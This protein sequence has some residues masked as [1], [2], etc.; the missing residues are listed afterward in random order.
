MARQHPVSLDDLESV[1][2]RMERTLR[3]GGDPGKEAARGLYLASRYL[4]LA[5]GPGDVSC[6]D[7][8]IDSCADICD[9]IRDV[10]IAAGGTGGTY[11]ALLRM[12]KTTRLALD[13]LVVRMI[14]L[15][16][17]MGAGPGR[18]SPP[19]D[20]RMDAGDAGTL[21]RA[22]AGL[23]RYAEAGRFLE[24]AGDDTGLAIMYDDMGMHHKAA[25]LFDCAGDDAEDGAERALYAGIAL[26][27]AGAYKEA[28]ESLGRAGGGRTAAYY[29]AYSWYRLGEYGMAAD[30]YGRAGGLGGTADAPRMR[31]MMLGMDGN[32]G[33]RIRLPLLAAS[34][35][36]GFRGMPELQYAVYLVQRREGTS[37]YDF[38]RG[39]FGPYS[40]DLERDILSNT[41]L[42]SVDP[43]G[44]FEGPRTCRI[45]PHGRRLLSGMARPAD[46]I[47]GSLMARYSGIPQADLVDLA[48][49]E[50]SARPDPAQ[51][52]KK[53]AEA[54]DEA[55][56]RIDAGMHPAFEYVNLHAGHARSVLDGAGASGGAGRAVSNIAGLVAHACGRVRL[57]AGPPVDHARLRTALADLE[58]SGRLLFGYCK[59]RGVVEYPRIGAA[60]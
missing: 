35:P 19:D 25:A 41:R 28:L 59:G 37:Q 20:P 10:R 17:G 40:G 30:L 9:R 50:F 44:I 27:H 1:V 15:A 46:H 49:K 22:L 52:I 43:G 23:G 26:A 34:V 58:E 18:L 54:R 39:G 14:C 53:L 5:D 13:G 11:D 48:Y 12:E 6:Y 8:M 32:A 4:E 29:M 33:G 21:G 24:A 31:A 7:G 38:G 56:S 45:T 57:H 60:R 2:D 36:G 51:L 47:T 16:G 55:R 3:A 42:F